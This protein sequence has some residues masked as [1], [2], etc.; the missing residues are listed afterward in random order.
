M[1]RIKGSRRG[2]RSL[3][4][5]TK[6]V[7][8]ARLIGSKINS[9]VDQTNQDILE[10]FRG[11]GLDYVPFKLEYNTYSVRGSY[12]NLYDPTKTP[13]KKDG[14][15]GEVWKSVKNVTLNLDSKFLEYYF[16]D[17]IGYDSWLSSNHPQIS[18]AHWKHVKLDHPDSPQYESLKKQYHAEV[19]HQLQRPDILPNKIKTK[20][21]RID[22]K[23]S[24]IL[25]YV[26]EKQSTTEHG[27]KDFKSFTGRDVE[28]FFEG[29]GF[30][31]KGNI[32]SYLDE[33]SDERIQSVLTA[34]LEKFNEAFLNL[35]LT[36]T[37]ASK[38][39][40][41]SQK[42]TSDKHKEFLSEI[43]EIKQQQ[44]KTPKFPNINNIRDWFIRTGIFKS[45][46]FDD[47]L[48]IKTVK[49]R[50]N[51]IDRSVFLIANGVYANALGQN[52]ASWSGKY[53]QNAGAKIPISKA[54]KN[55]RQV[56]SD[57]YKERGDRSKYQTERQIKYEVWRKANTTIARGW[58]NRY[59][60]GRRKKP[61]S[62]R[63]DDRV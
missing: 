26:R 24:T 32:K 61:T 33:N 49:G 14:T 29:E 7:M 52:T 9:L 16:Q 30:L 63:T 21:G 51:F 36:E 13:Y 11:Q 55:K 62:S 57:L 25:G 45:Y 28:K 22:Q 12:N 40:I 39:E 46:K 1:V 35:D 60:K 59:D 20:S 58:Y 3:T 48:N 56:K 47:F 8:H 6:K 41:E 34:A 31:F 2:D 5:K 27:Q 17:K 19:P 53:K 10:M 43:D 38:E 4:S 54:R 18:R 44:I 42:K 23:A 37:V 50:M 15:E